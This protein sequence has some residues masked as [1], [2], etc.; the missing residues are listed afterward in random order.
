MRRRGLPAV[1]L[2]VGASCLAQM[3]ERRELTATPKFVEDS[4]R[5]S[6]RS[7]TEGQLRAEIKI[8]STRNYAMFGY[9]TPEVRAKLPQVSNSDYSQIEFSPATLVDQ[10]D[11]A[12]SFEL[13]EG[14]YSEE[15]FSAEIRFR[16]PDSDS[17]KIVS[18]AHV[19]GSVKVKYPLAVKTFTITPT[20]PGPRKLAV[21]IDG[22]YVSFAEE[23]AKLPDSSTKL[24]PIRAYDAAGRQLAR[25]GYSE[26]TSEQSGYIKH[27]AFYGKVARVEMDSV[28]SWAELDLPYDLTPAPLLP[29]GHEGEDPEAPQQ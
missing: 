17:D 27:V 10:A 8:T 23:E 20:Q 4:V 19:R 26:T 2:L 15:K 25:Y 22:P 1:L 14:G 11:Q 18:F 6:F 21:K 16:N 7:F 5:P 12:V 24:K 28:E 9:N 29:A 3:P 13:E